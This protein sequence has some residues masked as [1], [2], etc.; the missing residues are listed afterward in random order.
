MKEIILQLLKLLSD[1]AP[2]VVPL[3]A[4]YLGWRLGYFSER[5][6]RK[7]EE[8][9]KKF[10]ALRE[11]K[12]VIDNIP[13][14][15]SLDELEHRIRTEP[16]LLS[17]LVHRLGRLF[18]LRRELIPHLDIS[19]MSIIDNQ[20]SPLFKSETGTIELIPGKE[21]TFAKSCM[22]LQREINSL[23]EK[24]ISAHKKLVK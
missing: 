10:H 12:G 18:G 21:D 5:R 24:L 4:V 16:E 19:I 14:N 15:V 2:Y 11:L 23:E 22:E 8:L 3:I 20:L 17:S 9:D 13:K 6:K 7:F 1:I